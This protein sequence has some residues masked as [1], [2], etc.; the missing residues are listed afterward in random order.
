MCV[1]VYGTERHF[2]FFFWDTVFHRAWT[3]WFQWAP[4]IFLSTSPAVSLYM[5]RVCLIVWCIHTHNNKEESG[6]ERERGWEGDGG[7]RLRIL[8]IFSAVAHMI[9]DTASP[10]IYRVTWQARSLADQSERKGLLSFW[11]R[12]RLCCIEALAWLEEAHPH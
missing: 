12:G 6:R 1:C 9:T 8:R 11:G 2:F 10:K 3:Q 5:T 4:K 7:E